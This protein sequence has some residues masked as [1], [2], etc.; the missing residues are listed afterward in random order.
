MP[1]TRY[2]VNGEIERAFSLAVEAGIQT[3]A[4]KQIDSP[5]GDIV[6]FGWVSQSDF[7]DTSFD[8]AIMLMPDIVALSLRIDTVR[9]PSRTLE[10]ALKD[11][12]ETVL[13]ETGQTRLSSAQR[14]ELKDRVRETLR[15]RTLPTIQVHDIVWDVPN[16]VL[17]LASI[18]RKV[19]DHVESL[20]KKSFPGFPLTPL[21]PYIR[22]EELHQWDGVLDQL[23]NLTPTHSYL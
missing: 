14:R 15:K 13:T 10:L 5:D 20:F 2:R 11:A 3:H 12:T 19:M 21:I 6:G 23:K 1:L 22:A 7:S 4:F 8:N 16:R 9:I 18:S 17:Y